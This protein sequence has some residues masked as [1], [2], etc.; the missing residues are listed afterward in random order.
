M[1]KVD[2]EER[3]TDNHAR[4]A[5]IYS[6]AYEGQY[7]ELPR[8]TLF[9]V[10]GPGKEPETRTGFTVNEVGLA[11]KDWHFA[12][13]IRMWEADDKD[14]SMCIDIESGVLR[15]ILLQPVL[16]LGEEM[17]FRGAAASRGAAAAR[18]AAAGRGAVV[19]RGA[20]MTRDPHRNK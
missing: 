11:A 14:M 1:R 15:E 2:Y 4:F 13:D 6:F 17:A 7:H 10:R 18:G 12:S 3:A 9:L 5:R 8:P 16:E 20:A 19:A